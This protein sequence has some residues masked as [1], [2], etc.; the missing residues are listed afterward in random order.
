MFHLFL[1]SNAYL[2]SEYGVL[3]VVVPRLLIPRDL[4]KQVLQLRR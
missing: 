1:D 4:V 2:R 3:V